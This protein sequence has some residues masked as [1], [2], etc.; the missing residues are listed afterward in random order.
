MRDIGNKGTNLTIYSDGTAI[1]D[2]K[3]L[4]GRT[5]STEIYWE[6]SAIEGCYLFYLEPDVRALC[7]R[8]YAYGNEMRLTFLMGPWKGIT[9]FYRKAW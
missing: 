2:R 5:L 4:F 6:Y 8:A 1:S 3:G 7:G 9:Y